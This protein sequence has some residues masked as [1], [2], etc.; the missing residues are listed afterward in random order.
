MHLAE[1]LKIPLSAS[2][3][4]DLPTPYYKQKEITNRFIS[5][6][7]SLF[8]LEFE[9]YIRAYFENSSSTMYERSIGVARLSTIL[10]K[11]QVAFDRSENRF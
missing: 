11:K 8:L 1:K 10:L 9:F 7:L 4:F 3:A 5:E 6:M 2:I